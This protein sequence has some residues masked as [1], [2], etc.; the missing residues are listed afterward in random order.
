VI[1]KGKT[2]EI[3]DVKQRKGS[4]HDLRVYKETIGKAVVSSIEI[5]A[6]LGYRGIEKL[7]Q[8]SLT[9]KKASKHHKLT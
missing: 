5:N 8:N 6:D 4:V 2:R 3:I 9:P 1:I 7:H